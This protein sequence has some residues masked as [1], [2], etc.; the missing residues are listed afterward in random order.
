MCTGDGRNN[1][2]VDVGVGGH[3]RV[4][5]LVLQLGGNCGALVNSATGEQTLMRPGYKYVAK[6]GVC[7]AVT[8][9]RCATGLA[10]V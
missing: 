2:P 8:L 10:A 1:A 7:T 9:C 6:N 3:K 4:L 5:V